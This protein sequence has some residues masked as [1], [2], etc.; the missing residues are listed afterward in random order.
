MFCYWMIQ[1]QRWSAW[2][3]KTTNNQHWTNTPRPPQPW[4]SEKSFNCLQFLFH[5]PAILP[6]IQSIYQ[7]PW[8]I[9]NNFSISSSRVKTLFLNLKWTSG[10]NL[11]RIYIFMLFLLS[12]A[13]NIRSKIWE[14][15][16]AGFYNFFVDKFDKC[17]ATRDNFHLKW[18]LFQEVCVHIL[19]LMQKYSKL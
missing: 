1:W 19:S 10:G 18:K 9:I 8:W 11:V 17:K 15:F 12:E 7:V 6:F 2:N 14:V 16:L 3:T 13:I 5:L 4:H